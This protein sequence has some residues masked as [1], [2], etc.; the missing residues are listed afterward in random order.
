M[1]RILLV[2]LAGCS[3]EAEYGPGVRCESD[4]RCPDGLFCHFGVCGPNRTLDGGIDAPPADAMVDA[5]L[6]ALT[7]ADP[8]VVPAGGGSSAGTTAGRSS[9]VSAMCNGSI[10][11][12]GDAVY[13]I[14]LAAPAMLLVAITGGREA[15]VL[16]SCEPAPATPVCTGS[17]AATEGNPI[18]PSLPAGT[19]FIVVDDATAGST[20]SYSLDVTVQ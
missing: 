13:R 4:G 10:M 15:Y 6:A 8:G 12:G 5:R 17:M 2:L 3:F 18:A 14:D 20:G 9:L 11:N 16:A 7:C 1:P 19:H